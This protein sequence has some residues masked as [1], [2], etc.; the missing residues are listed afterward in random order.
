[1]VICLWS[2][3]MPVMDKL[4]IRKRQRESIQEAH[5]SI[6]NGLLTCVSL[7]TWLTILGGKALFPY[8]SWEITWVGVYIEIIC[9]ISFG[10]S[11]RY[12]DWA[13]P[14]FLGGLWLCSLLVVQHFGP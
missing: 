2:L 5:R 11:R 4:S 13:I 7:G 12:L 6:F 3:G 14:M 9:G 10:L 1:M 8:L